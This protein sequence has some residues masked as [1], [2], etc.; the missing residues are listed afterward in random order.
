MIRIVFEEAKSLC[1]EMMSGYDHKVLVQQPTHKL[2]YL[3]EYT[4]DLNYE[5]PLPLGHVTTTEDSDT[6]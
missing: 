4:L 2:I 3:C 5:E 1:R 6:T